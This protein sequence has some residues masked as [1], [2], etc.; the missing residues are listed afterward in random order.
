[1]LV[2]IKERGGRGVL[3]HSSLR[4]YA[5]LRGSFLFISEQP[6]RYTGCESSRKMKIVMC[7]GMLVSHGVSYS[8][9]EGRRLRLCVCMVKPVKSF[10][11]LI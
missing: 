10:T 2:F 5:L 6:V 1:M 9:R 11:E 7:T 3:G 4:C 8:A